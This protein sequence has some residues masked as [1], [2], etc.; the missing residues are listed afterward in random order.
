MIFTLRMFAA[1]IVSHINGFDDKIRLDSTNASFL[2]SLLPSSN[3]F[4]WKSFFTS[5]EHVK[6]ST[7]HISVCN[8]VGFITQIMM[9]YFRYLPGLFLSIEYYM[10]DKGS[11]WDLKL[12]IISLYRILLHTA[13]GFAIFKELLIFITKPLCQIISENMGHSIYGEYRV[14]ENKILALNLALM[15][16]YFFRSLLKGLAPY[17]WKRINV[18]IKNKNTKLDTFFVWTI[19]CGQW[20]FQQRKK[21]ST[22]Q[23][24]QP[25]SQLVAC[26]I[27]FDL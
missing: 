2:Y 15:N 12:C 11:I 6:S 20:S 10:I 27:I 17:M 8:T 3:V 24:E 7:V 14:S 16:C 22:I 25:I 1:I 19:K 5:L 9:Q 21:V 13:M 4:E 23:W 18:K 26:A